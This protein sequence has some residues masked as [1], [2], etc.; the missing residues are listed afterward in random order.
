MAVSA[1]AFLSNDL[2]AGETA[3]YDRLGCES[4]TTILLRCFAVTLRIFVLSLAGISERKVRVS[5]WEID[6]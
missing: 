5:G 4:V 3:T 6:T 2:G 1:L